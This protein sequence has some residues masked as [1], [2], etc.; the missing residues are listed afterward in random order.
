MNDVDVRG[1]AKAQ[2]GILWCILGAII[3]L[4]LCIFV[5][6]AFNILYLPLAIIEIYFVYKLLT[7]LK[8]KYWILW[9]IGIIIPYLSLILLLVL[10]DRATKTIKQ[11]GYK[12]GLMGARL[13]DIK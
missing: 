3:I 9:I 5:A 8:S 4:V 7:A 12:V 1:V 6:Q 10:N 11:H 13:D 2:K